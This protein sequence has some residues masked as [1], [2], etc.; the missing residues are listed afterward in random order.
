[1]NRRD[2]FTLAELIIVTIIIL[3]LA[4]L[5]TPAIHKPSPKGQISRVQNDIRSISL[6]MESYRIANGTYPASEMDTP[7]PGRTTRIE[8][9]LRLLTTPQAYLN[10]VPQDVFRRLAQDPNPEF[11]VYAVAYETSAPTFAKYPRTAWM[12]WSIGLDMLDNTGG[13][14]AI[15]SVLRNESAPFPCVGA[16]KTG[17]FIGGTGAL[18]GLRY[19]PTNG[20]YSYGDIY[21]FE[22]GALTQEK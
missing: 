12:T 8:V 21:R 15:R 1:M 9:D 17:K 20:V 13:Y 11:R 7:L 3:L 5:V 22:G 2:A 4:S 10:R 6:A 16:D 18:N 14:H 19:D